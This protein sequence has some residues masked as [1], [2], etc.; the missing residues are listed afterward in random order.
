MIGLS[1]PL[2]ILSEETLYHNKDSM[3][4]H[5]SA[6][7]AILNAYTKSSPKLQI[8]SNVQNLHFRPPRPRKIGECFAPLWKIPGHLFKRIINRITAYAIILGMNLHNSMLSE[9][10]QWLLKPRMQSIACA[11]EKSCLGSK[12]STASFRFL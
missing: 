6:Q 7:L 5:F 2:R 3:R 1:F 9:M 12:S 4:L 11:H 10:M 8:S